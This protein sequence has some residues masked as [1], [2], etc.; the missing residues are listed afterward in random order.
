MDLMTTAAI[1]YV[2]KNGIEKLLGPTFEY[3]GIGLKNIMIILH[4]I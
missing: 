4:N 3:F 1:A 2:S